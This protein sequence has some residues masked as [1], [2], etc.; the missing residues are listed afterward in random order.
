MTTT[1]WI[2]GY[3]L[4]WPFFLECFDSHSKEHDCHAFLTSTINPAA[5]GLSKIGQG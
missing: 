2:E 3:A 4:S 5:R 1:Q